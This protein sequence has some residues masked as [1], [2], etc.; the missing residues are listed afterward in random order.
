MH[1]WFIDTGRLQTSCSGKEKTA[2]QNWDIKTGPTIFSQLESC[3]KLCVTKKKSACK[4]TNVNVKK[5]NA[6]STVA[7]YQY[8]F[9]LRE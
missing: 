4:K 3:C 5:K 1:I 6:T 8:T 2:Q 7:N 9:R